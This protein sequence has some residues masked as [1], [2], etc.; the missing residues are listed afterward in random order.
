MSNRSLLEGAHVPSPIVQDLRRASER[1]RRADASAAARLGARLALVRRV[2]P[3]TL[4]DLKPAF[5]DLLRP[6]ARRLAEGGV[7]A[8]QVTLTAAA[9]SL[10]V[11]AL[12]C[13]PLA[14]PALF[15]L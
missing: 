9:G 7:T 4:Y 3:V 2:T 13:L 1:R 12:L 8:N 15:L 6:T 5:Q 11:G 10:V 14:Q